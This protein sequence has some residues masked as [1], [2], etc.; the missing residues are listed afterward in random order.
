MGVGK[1][2][3]C[4]S[5]YMPWAGSAEPTAGGLRRCSLT[6]RPF[7]GLTRSVQVALVAAEK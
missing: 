4:F 1:K 6:R 2:K 5:I 7:A 3:I